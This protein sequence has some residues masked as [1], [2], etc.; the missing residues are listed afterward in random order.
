M[1]PSGLRP[2]LPGTFLIDASCKQPFKSTVSFDGFPQFPAQPLC[3][4]QVLAI[5]QPT[6]ASQQMVQ[7]HAGSSSWTQLYPKQHLPMPP[8]SSVND[9]RLLPCQQGYPAQLHPVTRIPQRQPESSQLVQNT[10]APSYPA[11]HS[12][13]LV[14]P[15]DQ[16]IQQLPAVE[17]RRLADEFPFSY[18]IAKESPHIFG[19]LQ[20]DEILDHPLTPS[21]DAPTGRDPLWEA[22]VLESDYAKENQASSSNADFV[23]C[24]TPNYRHT[25][26]SR[27]RT[28]PTKYKG[29]C[30]KLGPRGKSRSL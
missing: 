5:V 12:L 23:D 17:P 22:L 8:Q 6:S 7:P 2:I 25:Q 16:D 14:N 29:F 28:V 15:I 20:E 27:L 10:T 18:S 4:P 19:D 9:V 24:V 21:F 1:G 26:S 30:A 13:T 3:S 11:H